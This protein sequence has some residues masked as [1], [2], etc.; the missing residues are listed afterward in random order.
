MPKMARR[1]RKSTRSRKSNLLL[2]L[3]GGTL[4]GGVI[5]SFFP[6]LGNKIKSIIPTKGNDA[7]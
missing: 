5:I 3:L 6:S 4:L 7:I 2:W 1:R